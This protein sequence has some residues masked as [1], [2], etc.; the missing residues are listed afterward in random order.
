MTRLSLL[1][2]RLRRWFRLF[3]PL[4]V[5]W[6]VTAFVAAELVDAQPPEAPWW[7][8]VVLPILV[9]GLVAAG[10]AWLET[11]VLARAGRRL[12]LGLTLALR[13]ALYALVVAAAL[14]VMIV[15]VLPALTGL[16]LSTLIEDVGVEQT[17]RRFWSVLVLLVLGSFV[18]NLALQLRRVLGGGTL[19]A[20]LVGRYLRPTPEE[21][22][23]MFLDLTDST[24][25]AER[26]GPFRFT[27]FKNDFFADVAQPVL[28]TRGQIYQYVGDEVVITW[29]MAQ[30][31][32]GGAF[33]RCFFLLEDRVQ[34]RAAYYQAT[35][36][37]VPAFKAGCHGGEVV[38][39][40]IGDLKS[41][42][43]Y[44]GDV[45]NTAARIEGQ[46]R[47]L[48]Y[49]LLISDTLLER[50]PLPDG[51]TAE[52]VGTVLLRGKAEALQLYSI[53]GPRPEQA[54]EH[55]RT[56]AVPSG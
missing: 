1:E 27:D 19:W 26:L 12:P 25:I 21:R 16:P 5:S 4:W 46:C 6:A 8:S 38:T 56:A 41:D 52:E 35:Y 36:G 7:H 47:P 10:G 24:A 51:L 39:A 40:F 29:P 20:L 53:S 28:T 9:G 34:R 45:V 22:L 54:S 15:R 49:R 13:T 3:L 2:A 11:G 44:S 30:G 42:L 32:R 37:C 43:A 14:A 55:E 18:I 33:L 31:L 50:C 17:I 48:G 23:F